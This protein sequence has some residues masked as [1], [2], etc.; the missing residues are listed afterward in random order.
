[1]GD[2]H[3]RLRAAG[4]ALDEWAPI[5]DADAIRSRTISSELSLLDP[6]T[7]GGDDRGSDRGERPGVIRPLVVLAGVAAAVLVVLL[8][9]VSVLRDD[10]STIDTGP[11]ASVPEPVEADDGQEVQVPVLGQ[12]LPDVPDVLE[13]TCD[14][15][16]TV[17]SSP[18]VQAQ[19][20]GV[21][22][23]VHNPH[24]M[25]VVML[26][27]GD[28]SMD[29]PVSPIRFGT[30]ELVMP[31]R[32]GPTTLS[33]QPANMAVPTVEVEVLDPLG[34][35]VEP[36]LPCG[37]IASDSFNFGMIPVR[38]SVE[39]AVRVWAGIDEDTVLRSIRYPGGQRRDVVAET[40]QGEVAF[41]VVDFDDTGRWIAEP[42]RWCTPGPPGRAE[43][44]DPVRV[45][46]DTTDLE[47][48]TSLL[49]GLDAS[50]EPLTADDAEHVCATVW[51][52][53]SSGEQRD[54]PDDID[55][56]RAAVQA[57]LD[58][59]IAGDCDPTRFGQPPGL[60][61]PDGAFDEL[62]DALVALRDAVDDRS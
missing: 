41:R 4:D 22:F 55:R 14:G 13:L 29:F 49:V 50:E 15:D 59:S 16:A 24:P 17:L 28:P 38:P 36:A 34:A 47:R 35:Y 54:T 27:F 45:W 40:D 43:E 48:L 2:L 33:C 18:R 12:P 51:T 37:A 56:L 7:A 6:G 44:R 26:D 53:A 5:F 10:A 8:G 58:A 25:G 23:L 1:M 19:V 39:E 9:G 62:R 32:P 61:V 46:Y 60:L 21:H 11:A 20:D 52:A 3:E 30:E 31:V 42:A 57:E